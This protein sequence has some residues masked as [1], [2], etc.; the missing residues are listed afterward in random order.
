MVTLSLQAAFADAILAYGLRHS[1][2]SALNS[3]AS[4]FPYN[5]TIRMQQK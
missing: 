1:D 4:L 2:Q 3:A 5:R